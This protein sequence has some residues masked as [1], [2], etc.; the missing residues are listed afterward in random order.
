MVLTPAVK[1]LQIDSLP[2]Q[3][4]LAALVCTAPRVQIDQALVR[5]SYLLGYAFEIAN[6]VFIQTDRDLLF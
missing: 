2:I 3:I 4:K 6:G 1:A 5:N